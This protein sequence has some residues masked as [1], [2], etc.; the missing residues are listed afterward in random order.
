MSSLKR[1]NHIE[2]LY[3][4]DNTKPQTTLHSLKKAKI[5]T[6]LR[7][8]QRKCK[9]LREQNFIKPPN[10]SK[11]GKK[12]SLNEEDKMEIEEALDEDPTLTAREIKSTVDLSCG[13]RTI[14][15][16]L[17]RINIIGDLC[18]THFC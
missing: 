7:T 15:R 8:V 9:Q 18:L 1:D 3:Q 16:H 11:R 5:E 17:K 2:S 10:Y 4:S 14:Q 12:P 6:S 13:L